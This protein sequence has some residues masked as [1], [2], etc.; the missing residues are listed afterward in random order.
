MQS[1][2]AGWQRT[3]PPAKKH[4]FF[5][6]DGG[7]LKTYKKAEG[8][9]ADIYQR[10]HYQQVQRQLADTELHAGEKNQTRRY[11]LRAMGCR[12]HDRKYV[13]RISHRWWGRLVI[14]TAEKP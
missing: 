5:F 3:I 7:Y 12:C 9:A 13:T 4:A 11:G 2:T 1:Q 14:L 6:A 10:T 8:I